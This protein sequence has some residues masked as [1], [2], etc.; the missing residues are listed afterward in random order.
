MGHRTPNGNFPAGTKRT[1]SKTHSAFNGLLR[2]LSTRT[3]FSHG[4][5]QGRA[6]VSEIFH[7]MTLKLRISK[8]DV[9]K[10]VE[11][12]LGSKYDAQAFQRFQ[13]RAF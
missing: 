2:R 8:L 9:A 13:R 3:D 11:K 6:E 1:A 5:A 10:E 4:C 7:F 12:L